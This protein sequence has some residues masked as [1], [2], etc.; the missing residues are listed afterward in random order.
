MTRT[1][2]IYQ[3]EEMFVGGE[4]TLS[5]IA[6]K[7]LIQVLRLQPKAQFHLFDGAGSE[8]LAEYIGGNK[9]ALVAKIL[10][11]THIVPASNLKIHLGQGISRGDKMDYAI[12]KAVE[13]GVAE[14]TPLFTQNS[15]IKYNKERLASKMEHWQG[16]IIHAA[17]QSGRA[18][19]PKLN[20][21]MEFS[22]WIKIQKNPTFI[23][24][25]GATNQAALP[26]ELNALALCIGAEG[27]WCQQ[28]LDL[29]LEQKLFNLNLGPRVLRTETAVPV[30]LT[31]LQSRWGDIPTP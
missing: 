12:Q 23:C 2:R 13:L 20:A 28:E 1:I 11:S 14:I 31:L 17:Q 18:D 16:I 4:I 29:A 25:I 22:H 21:A 9:T 5:P 3:P 30:A 27:G 6:S 15:Q 7:H 24:A 10:A 8:F 26:A 19:L